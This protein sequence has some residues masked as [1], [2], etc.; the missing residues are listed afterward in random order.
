MH[1]LVVPVEDEVSGPQHRVA[2]NLLVRG[3]DD[4]N[5]APGRGA[6]VED[7]VA[8][9]HA[10]NLLTEAKV[11]AAGAVAV[12]ALRDVVALAVVLGVQGLEDRVGGRVVHARDGG[13]RV[14]HDVAVVLVEAELLRLR[15]GDAQAGERHGQAELAGLAAD[16]GRLLQLADE[17]VAVQAAVDDGAR[18]GLGVAQ[19]EGECAAVDD[20][21]VGHGGEHQVVGLVAVEA[22]AQVGRET[23][24]ALRDAIARL[25]DAERL[26]RDIGAAEAQRL[27]VVADSRRC[28][29]RRVGCVAVVD[30]LLAEGPDG[31]RAG[32][33]GVVLAKG[34][35][36]RLLLQRRRR[37]A[38]GVDPE[39]IGARVDEHDDGLWRRAEF[40]C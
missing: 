31:R 11:D 16:D 9:R 30:R 29:R 24:D 37:V 8:E 3:D 34:L 28:M 20:A 26:V 2:E 21:L 23:Q 17:L 32:L 35:A 10:H 39:L 4:A 7:E 40:D 33:V 14:E 15:E 5:V 19:V 18:L 25:D 6:E 12:R 36:L 1:I 13:A 22:A 27:G 38:V